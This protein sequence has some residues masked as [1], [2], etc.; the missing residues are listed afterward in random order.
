MVRHVLA[1]HPVKRKL[2]FDDNPPKKLELAEEYFKRLISIIEDDF[3]HFLQ[4]YEVLPRTAT[5]FDILDYNQFNTIWRMLPQTH[6]EDQ[7]FQEDFR[8][9]MRFTEHRETAGYYRA[10]VFKYNDV[11]NLNETYFHF[12]FQM[13]WT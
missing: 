13:F 11:L 10:V 12:Y 1:T 3:D 5:R 6:F 4:F 7:L 9:L 8:A 2:N